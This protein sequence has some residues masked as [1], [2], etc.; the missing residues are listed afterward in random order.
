MRMFVS[1]LAVALVASTAMAASILQD[2]GA[3]TDGGH[4]S[5]PNY[6]N[7]TLTRPYAITSDGAFVGGTAY[8]QDGTAAAGFCYEVATDKNNMVVAG[9]YTTVI[10]GIGYTATGK[11]MV[12]GKD[13][14]WNSV[15]ISGN[16]GYTWS[17]KRYTNIGPYSLG[18]FN[19]AAGVP[20]T[21]N[22]GGHGAVGNTYATMYNAADGGAL[23]AGGINAADG[24]IPL[25]PMKSVPGTN[26]YVGGISSEGVGVGKRAGNNYVVRLDQSPNAAYF[27]GLDPANNNGTAYDISDD[28]AWAVGYSKKADGSNRAYVK[29]MSDLAGLATELPGLAGAEA[30]YAYGI[31][32]AG[33][34]A[35][36][37]SWSSAGGE[38]AVLWDLTGVSPT[39]LDLTAFAT[40]QGIMGDFTNL[41]KSYSVGVNANGEPVVAGRGSTAGGEVGWVL[42]VPEPA[43]LLLLALGLPFLRRRRS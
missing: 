4:S 25:F 6:V 34:Y 14:G 27:K 10:S 41:F 32:G 38:Q 29:D 16:N 15:N 12:N 30:T 36:G 40:G 35:T 43:S 24:L 42:T 11:L 31:S 17:K 7:H 5:A 1:M 20:S 13:S 22:S 19:T 3:P 8:L 23:Y 21:T 26:K 2:I 18:S 9:G 33:E 39:V 28:G 37:I